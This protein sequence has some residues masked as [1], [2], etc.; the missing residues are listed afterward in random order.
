MSNSI[1]DSSLR[2]CNGFMDLN[3]MNELINSWRRTFLFIR[4]E[5]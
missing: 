5:F 3:K 1:S 4:K 2:P